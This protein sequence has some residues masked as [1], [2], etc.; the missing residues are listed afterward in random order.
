MIVALVDFKL[1]WNA[2]LALVIMSSSLMVSP[3]V[4]VISMLRLVVLHCP[5]QSAVILLSVGLLLVMPI[6]T[7]TQRVTMHTLSV[8][9]EQLNLP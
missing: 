2:S 4:K 3:L 5:S 1:F 8:L 9:L 6:I 7:G